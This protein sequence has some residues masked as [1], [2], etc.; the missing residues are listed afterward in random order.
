LELKSLLG[1]DLKDPDVISFIEKLGE[2]PEFITLD[3]EVH[4]AFKQ[5][6][7][8]FLTDSESR[9]T[10]IFLYGNNNEG[11]SNYAGTL[12]HNLNFSL[13]Q[14]E[15]RQALGPPSK[16]GRFSDILNPELLIIWDRYSDTYT[17]H[18]GYDSV[19]HRITMITLMT[20]QNTP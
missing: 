14:K 3:E 11:F 9:L 13:T 5:S 4:I 18:L 12:P 20:L 15:V 19:E 6:G 10:T 2:P 1:K 8:S 16:S 17:L 7:I